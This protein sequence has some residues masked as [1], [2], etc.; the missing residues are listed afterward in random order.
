MPVLQKLKAAYLLWFEY[1]QT[2][3][4]THRYTLGVKID[5]IFVEGIEMVASASFLSRQEKIPYVRTA[6][7]K[8]DTAKILLLIL[9]ETRSLDTKKYGALSEKIEEVGR[10]LGGWHGQLAKQN[11]SGAMQE[12]K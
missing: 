9:W 12:E 5:D 11:S 7:R 2:I 10:M 4:K 6:I 8:I 1:Y 3:P